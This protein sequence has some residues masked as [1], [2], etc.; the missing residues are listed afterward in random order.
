MQQCLEEDCLSEFIFFF[1]LNK[2]MQN[3][4]QKYNIISQTMLQ[5]SIVFIYLAYIFYVS[6]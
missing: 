6:L 4:I 1:G 5:C 2:Y 3:Q